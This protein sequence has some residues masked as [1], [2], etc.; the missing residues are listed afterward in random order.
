MDALNKKI[1]N[2]IVWNVIAIILFV[3]TCIM[4]F[5][6]SLNIHAYPLL[7]A[8]LDPL[9]LSIISGPVIYLFIIKPYVT[10]NTQLC[11]S[12][13]HNAIAIVESREPYTSGHMRRVANLSRL[14]AKR[15]N[16]SA[17]MID[18]VFYA[19]L[20]HDLGKIHIPVEILIYPGKL[21][22]EAFSLVKIHSK[23]GFD[24]LTNNELP[25][26]LAEVAIQHHERLDGS[27]YPNGLKG[28]AILLEAQ[29]VAVADVYDAVTSTRPYRSALNS[30]IALE[31]LI[32]DAG[33]RLNVKAVRACVELVRSGD[34]KAEL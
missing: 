8:F 34:Y 1:A 17:K 29:I 9:L 16:L 26:P 32:A 14:I 6:Y 7:T 27:G 15:L 10:K 2:T 12:V 23:A 19:A 5:L 18:D 24:I 33:I 28:D 30:D 21:E 11:A 25:W 3:E 20:V 4:L 13:V 22:P 31:I